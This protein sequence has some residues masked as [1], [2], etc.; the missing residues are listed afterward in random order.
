MAQSRE[1]ES[2][3]ASHSGRS[4]SASCSRRCDRTSDA[5]AKLSGRFEDGFQFGRVRGESAQHE[6]QQ[7]GP[8]HEL[9]DEDVL[10]IVT[11]R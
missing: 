8:D 10:R 3:S 4:S 11:D 5:C 2:I 1:P 9:R 7:V 6:D